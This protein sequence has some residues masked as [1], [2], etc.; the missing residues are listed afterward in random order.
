MRQITDMIRGFDFMD[1][2]PIMIFL[3]LGLVIFLLMGSNDGCGG[4]FDQ[5]NSLIWIVLIIFILFL[6]NNNNYDDCDCC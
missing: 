4:F 2:N 6:L 5:G 3:I 1:D